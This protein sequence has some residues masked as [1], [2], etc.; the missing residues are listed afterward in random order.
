MVV[1]YMII[2]W[3]IY[4]A[5]IDPAS[6]MAFGP[7]GATWV[8][9]SWFVAGVIG[10]NLSMYGMAGVEA[11]MLMEPTWNVGDAMRLMM[12]AESTWSGPG[13]WMKTI[14]WIMQMRRGDGQRKLPARLWFVLALPSMLVFTAWPLSGLTMETTSGFLHGR[15]APTVIDFSY[16]NFNER[17]VGNVFDGARTIWNNALDARIP[18]QGIAYTP[19]GYA[20]SQ[21]DYLTKVPT[22]LPKD[23]GIGRTFLTAQA[24]N[25]IEGNAWG[26]ELQY[27]CTI[28]E[29][30][31]DLSVLKYRNASAYQ[32]PRPAGSLLYTTQGDSVR[33]E[34]RNQTTMS[35]SNF[36]YNMYRVIELGSQ[37]WPN[38]TGV[39]RLQ[40]LKKANP[41]KPDNSNPVTDCYYNEAENAT[42]DYPG[43]DEERVFEVL[44]W[45]TLLNSTLGT[46]TPPAYNF[47]LDHNITELYG[48]Y[49]FGDFQFPVPTN[50][51]QKRPLQP[52]SAIGVQCRSSS[53]V[54]TADI[55]GV[56]SSYSNFVRT[57]TPNNGIQAR[58]AQRFGPE[59]PR[60]ILYGFKQDWL[61]TLFTSAAVPPTLYAAYSNDPTDQDS[62]SGYMV[63]LS[64]LS[65][66]QLRQSM[67][68]AY[69][70]YAVQLMYNGGQGFSALD[71]THIDFVN[72]NM[73]EFVPDTVIKAGVMS[74]S[75]PVALFLA[76][77]MVASVLGVVY[78]F[79]RR[80][81]ATLDGYAMFRLGADLS[82]DTKEKIAAHTN[83]GEVVDCYALN[84]VPGLVGDTRPELCLG[85]IGLVESSRAEKEKM[86]Q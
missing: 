47:T 42:G 43:I 13:G 46:G 20:R 63:Q 81:S 11:A 9:Y 33:I 22:I 2:I 51:T 57:D 19:K 23:G 55:D 6:P 77:A 26:L 80:W 67:L 60:S 31:S 37:V 85:H 40:A 34:V 29:K 82:Y 1:S 64:Y 39:E 8:L 36:A 61:S 65:A 58:C 78:G 53:N 27:N 54:G 83:T 75:I 48:A 5:P 68:R 17:Y 12:H 7:P 76:W 74:A 59:I 79:R 14:K 32:L 16:I 24:E 30:F 21:H 41:S 10:L 28:V 56:H 15:K 4:L 73:T 72:P 35:L 66:E 38:K 45:Q 84:H 62:N 52:M 71:G 50:Q 18:G 44:L 86:Y 49:N 25:P 69:A 70:A 3:R